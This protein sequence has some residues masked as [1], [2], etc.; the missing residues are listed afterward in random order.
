MVSIGKH[1]EFSVRT[2]SKTSNICDRDMFSAKV[3][4]CV[5]HTFP[6]PNTITSVG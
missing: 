4:Y 1:R 2:V 6:G 3:H 5:Q